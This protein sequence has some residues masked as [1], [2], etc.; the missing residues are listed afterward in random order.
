MPISFR[1]RRPKLLLTLAVVLVAG[2]VL[3]HPVSTHLRAMSV[4]LRFSSP[5]MTGFKVRFAQHPVAEETLSAQT[6]WG[7][8]RYRLYRPKDIADPPG[9]ILLHGIHDLGIEEPRLINFARALSGGGVEIMTP[10]LRDLADYHVTSHTVDSIGISTVILCT[11]MKVRKVGVTGM[12]FAGGLAL[13]AASKPEYAEHIGFVVAIG[14]H[15][16]LRRVSRFFATN[17]VEK[18]DGTTAPFP[19]HEYGVL[20]LAYA[21]L[22][23]LFSAEDVPIAR[24]ALR[25]WLHEKAELSLSTA[26]KLTPPGQQMF[27]MIL[28]HHDVLRPRLLQ[29]IE[30]HRDEMEP[31]SPHGQVG[32]ISMPVFLLH[33]AGDNVIPPTESEWLAHDL[34]AGGMKRLL[35]SPALIHVSMDDKV[36]LR[37]QWEL[38]DFIAQVLDRADQNH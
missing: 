4:L 30:A 1:G 24:E 18:P 23:D 15:D 35:I 10:E 17:T 29:E 20:V 19:A 28:H 34:P 6:P 38:I 26:K 36:T 13:L 25:L 14:A 22:E 27:D 16:D 2:L 11:Q 32:N 9:I 33:G 3:A 21:H 31:V 7:P 37:Q 12:S 5:K 8:L